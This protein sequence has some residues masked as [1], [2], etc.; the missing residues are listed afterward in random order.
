MRSSRGRRRRLTAMN[1]VSL[2][3]LIDTALTLL[4]IFMVA[5]PMMRNSIRVTLPKGQAQE[6]NSKTQDLVVQ[7][8][9]KKELQLNGDAVKNLDQLL[10]QLKKTVGNQ[11]DRVVH[12]YG[13]KNVDYGFVIELVDSLKSVGGIRHVALATQRRAA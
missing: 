13:A 4:I 9:E 1:D 5:T 10:A 12:V 8:N 3:P 6:D 7:I 2:T 11:Q